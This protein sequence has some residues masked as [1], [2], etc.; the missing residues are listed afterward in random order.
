MASPL[1]QISL[2]DD[3]SAHG[4]DIGEIASYLRELLPWV[5]VETR[6]DLAYYGD[7]LAA[8][9]RELARVWDLTW[10][11]RPSEELAGGR[12]R[13]QR[14][15]DDPD[16]LGLGDLYDGFQLAALYGERIPHSE[17]SRSHLHIAFTDNLFGTFDAEDL[18]FHARVIVL[19]QPALISTSGAVVAPARPR[20]YYFIKAQLMQLG[21]LT[22][23]DLEDL[24][25]EF[26]DRCLTHGDERT[27]EAL[28]GYA[29]QAVAYHLS[30]QAFCEDEGCRLF[31]A[32][33]QEEMLAAQCGPEAGVCAACAQRLST[34]ITTGGAE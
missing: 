13:P 3:P 24:E 8:L 30:G 18:R 26:S 10:P 9:D 33:W 23:E 21:R 6:D 31:D 22:D 29:L 27:T 2:Y 16:E 34:G 1:K 14:V 32:H 25:E 28:K 17:R 5:A 20:E 7:P 19:G 11:G 15:A 12:P 4:L